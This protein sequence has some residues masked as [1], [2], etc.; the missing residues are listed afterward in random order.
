M[1]RVFRQLSSIR[2][3]VNY[4]LVPC[5]LVLLSS[6][7]VN[8]AAAPLTIENFVSP[9]KA[10]IISIIQTVVLAYSAHAATIRPENTST[11]WPTVVKRTLA[12]AWPVSG[13]HE[14]ISS[15]IKA[16]KGYKIL[17]KSNFLE[18]NLVKNDEALGEW[19]NEM[20]MK[21]FDMERISLLVERRRLDRRLEV[22]ETDIVTM[23]EELSRS[24]PEP[25]SESL[26]DANMRLYIRNTNIKYLES[27]LK[28]REVVLFYQTLTLRSEHA[29]F[30][31][32]AKFRAELYHYPYET[33]INQF[34]IFAQETEDLK[35]FRSKLTIHDED[36]LN[37]SGL[38]KEGTKLLINYKSL[39]SSSIENPIQSTASKEAHGLLNNTESGVTEKGEKYTVMKAQN[40]YSYDRELPVEDIYETDDELKEL[41]NLFYKYQIPDKDESNIDWTY[42]YNNGAYL[43]AILERMDSSVA[44]TTKG[45]MINGNI[46]IGIHDFSVGLFD[47][48]TYEWKYQ[49]AY[50]R[51]DEMDITGPGTDYDYQ[52]AIHPAMFCYLPPDMLDQLNNIVALGE[53]Q[54]TSQLFTLVQLGYTVYEI[55]LGTGDKWS[56]L[57]MGVFMIMSVLQTVSLMI[58][59]TQSMSY[60]IKGNPIHSSLHEFVPEANPKMHSYKFKEFD[61]EI[62][63]GVDESEI[64]YISSAMRTL[65]LT[66]M[67][68]DD[69]ED[70]MKNALAAKTS[71]SFKNSGVWEYFVVFGGI[72]IP[73]IL[74]IAA[75]Y[76]AK[77]KTEWIVISWIVG[78]L[79]FIIFRIYFLDRYANLDLLYLILLVPFM[80]FPGIALVLAAT[81]IGYIPEFS[82]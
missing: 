2:T 8:S 75:G 44:T 33:R 39:P 35:S 21:V 67:P 72:A 52:V 14:A 9:T 17:N 36:V 54:I 40:L 42:K 62:F 58:L 43:S 26:D 81:I 11:I 70:V 10:A 31:E 5:V 79:P 69:L 55:V 63:N 22:I 51:T 80:A 73:L 48:D 27:S 16:Y 38:K 28:E 71:F 57:I 74:G 1:F 13:V 64:H 29:I 46:Y 4:T 41:A 19:M 45:F 15:M 6:F 49:K 37:T 47:Q 23:K 66:G 77:S 78:S 12:I 82:N 3:S 65:A 50:Q 60:S 56:K 18:K 68:L 76:G 32:H 61:P 7:V 59:P 53:S 24:A 30:S 25:S 20:K 34:K